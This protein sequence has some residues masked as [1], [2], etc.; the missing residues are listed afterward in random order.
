MLGRKTTAST[1]AGVAMILFEVALAVSGYQNPILAIILAVAAV[2]LFIPLLNELRKCAWSAGKQSWGLYGEPRPVRS[3][4]IVVLIGAVVGAGLFGGIAWKLRTAYR[5]DQASSFGSA[6]E[7]P[8]PAETEK[9]RYTLLSKIVHQITDQQ[10]LEPEERYDPI[11]ILIAFAN[12]FHSEE[13]VDWVCLELW[14]RGY[15]EPFGGLRGGIYEQCL[16]R[17]R[18]KFLRDAHVDLPDVRKGKD[19]IHWADFTWLKN[20]PPF[21]RTAPYIPPPKPPE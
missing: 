21:Q 18:L 3:M 16:A 13:D 6:S 9:A 5:K 10:Q 11:A 20:N 19:V 8:V 2:I 15:G 7:T 17:K 4:I 12:E 1:A 14:N